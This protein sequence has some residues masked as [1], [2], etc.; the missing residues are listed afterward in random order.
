[1]MLVLSYLEFTNPIVHVFFSGRQKVFICAILMF[2]EFEQIRP[3]G[4][5]RKRKKTII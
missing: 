1:M 2:V 3:E 4:V 5:V